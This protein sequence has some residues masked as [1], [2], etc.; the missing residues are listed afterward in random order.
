[1]N[2][3][4]GFLAPWMSGVVSTV[5]RAGDHRADLHHRP[6]WRELTLADGL[7]QVDA[8]DVLHDD[9]VSVIDLK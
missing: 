2:N 4:Q 6:E 9:R 7:R 8:V 1:M 3:A 5:Q